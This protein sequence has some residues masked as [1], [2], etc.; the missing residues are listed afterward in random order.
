MQA[1]WLLASDL[2]GCPVDDGGGGGAAAAAAGDGDAAGF[3]GGGGGDGGV[4]FRPGDFNQ[5][6]M[7]LGA[8]LCSP[9]TPTCKICPLQS[10]CRAYKEVV[11]D[12]DVVDDDLDLDVDLDL[13]SGEGSESNT[14]TT[15][16]STSS[17]SS[18][19]SSS[20]SS[21]SSSSS[22]TT[23]TRLTRKRRRVPHIVI[24]YAENEEERKKY[25]KKKAT[26][27][28]KNYFIRSKPF[29]SDI[30]ESF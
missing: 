22:T 12:V 26:F 25:G 7:E 21:S 17:S 29:L 28:K 27:V 13:G 11:V 5:S 1:C 4:I 19:S 3:G 9:T 15:S 10:I 16:D 2:M 20:P 23:S 14:T 18:S 30:I 8:T 6:L 24:D